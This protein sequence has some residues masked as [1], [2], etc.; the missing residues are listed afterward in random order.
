MKTI[1]WDKYLLRTMIILGCL[2]S[3]P[4]NPVGS[5]ERLFSIDRDTGRRLSCPNIE[6]AISDPVPGGYD[7]GEILDEGQGSFSSS[8]IYFAETGDNTSTSVVT[9]YMYWVEK[10]GGKEFDCGWKRKALDSRFVTSETKQAYIGTYSVDARYSDFLPGVRDRLLHQ[11]EVLAI[12][13]AGK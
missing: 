1:R 13:C 5:D 11:V 9:L 7:W 2:F 8:C 12:P 3:L 10:R 6:G 4:V